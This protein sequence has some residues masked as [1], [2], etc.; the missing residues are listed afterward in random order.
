[1]T[2]DSTRTRKLLAFA[3]AVGYRTAKITVG[4]V[5]FFARLQVATYA[6]SLAEGTT[7]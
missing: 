6:A 5:T 3:A 7:Q 2:D 1:M 4:A